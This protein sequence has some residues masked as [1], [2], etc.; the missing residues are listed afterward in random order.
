MM[1]ESAPGLVNWHP[2]NKVKRPG[3]HRLAC[4]QA[5]ACGSDTVQYF[6]WRKGRGS[7]EQFHGAV[8]DHLGTDDTRV[9]KEVAEVGEALGKLSNL[10]GTL[11]KTKAALLFDWDNRWAIQDVKALA[12]VLLSGRNFY[13]L[14]WTWMWWAPMRI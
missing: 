4:L 1:M 9:F 12:A 11:V 3:V 5:V 14:E 8:V 10:A 7:F 13:G 6:Q 2:V